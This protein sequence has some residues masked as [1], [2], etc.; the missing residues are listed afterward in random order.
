[1][2]AAALS[3]I[4]QNNTALASYKLWQLHRTTATAGTLDMVMDTF[5][6]NRAIPVLHHRTVI[7]P[8]SLFTNFLPM[9]NIQSNYK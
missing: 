4:T 2:E 1:M 3:W 8:S 7:H 5:I 6:V 9:V